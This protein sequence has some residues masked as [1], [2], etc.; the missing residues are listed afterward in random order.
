MDLEIQIQS[1]VFSLVFGMFFSLLFNLF[2]KYLFRG[3]FIFKLLINLFFVIVNTL[4]YFGLLCIIN[5][6]IIHLYFLIMLIIGFFVGNIKTRK[7]RKYTLDILWLIKY[8]C[9][10]NAH[11]F[12]LLLLDINDIKTNLVYNYIGVLPGG[13]WK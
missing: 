11:I 12:F 3:K 4:L 7:I 10:K 6:G 5:E 9:Y 8:E 2:Y 13:L 1:L